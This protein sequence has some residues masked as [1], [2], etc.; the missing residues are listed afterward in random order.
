MANVAILQSTSGSFTGTSG[1]FS[2]PNPVLPGSAIMLVVACAQSSANTFAPTDS[3]GSL[4]TLTGQRS[5]STP[6]AS[7]SIYYAKKV[8]GGS[9]T[10]T[11]TLIASSAAVFGAYEITKL[12]PGTNTSVAIDGSPAGTVGTATAVVPGAITASAA[13]LS[14]MDVDVVAAANASSLTYTLGAGYTALINAANGA[15]INLGINL[16][17]FSTNGSIPGAI[18][19][20]GVGN[21]L[22]TH[23][24]FISQPANQINNYQFVGSQ[25]TTGNAVMSV[26][27]KIR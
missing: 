27:E 25:D 23:A 2:F 19:Q 9:C 3:F 13:S 22:A 12:V 14:A 11:M 24:L 10:V 17:L 16:G 26:T 4:Y 21:W 18:T 15:S 8:T 6:T 5:S 1:S 7:I 20:S